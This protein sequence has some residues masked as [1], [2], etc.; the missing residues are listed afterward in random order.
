[1]QG[2]FDCR[3]NLTYAFAKFLTSVYETI[4]FIKLLGIIVR[5]GGLL[6]CLL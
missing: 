3:H 5:K 4:V 6:L 2:A 1:M